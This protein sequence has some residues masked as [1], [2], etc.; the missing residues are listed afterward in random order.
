[1]STLD[2][3]SNLSSC[4]ISKFGLPSWLWLKPHLV[5]LTWRRPWLLVLIMT[6]LHTCESWHHVPPV[7]YKRRNCTIFFCKFFSFTHYLKNG[8]TSHNAENDE[9]I[10]IDLSFGQLNH[11][12]GL[13]NFEQCVNLLTLFDCVLVADRNY[14]QLQI[15]D[16]SEQTLV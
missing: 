13:W 5:L 9:D 16:C 1:M 10:N 2:Q 7:K 15:K 6:R 11:N 14:L 8:Y 12:V 4:Y 3:G